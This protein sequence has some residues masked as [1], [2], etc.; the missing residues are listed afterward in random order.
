MR[1]VLQARLGCL[2]LGNLIASREAFHLEIEADHEPRFTS[3]TDGT[4]KRVPES[5]RA[6]VP[7][8]TRSLTST[9]CS[10]D[11]LR[12]TVEHTAKGGMG[13]TKRTTGSCA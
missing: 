11:N 5:Y 12:S 1:R 13:W 10:A 4:E 6:S 3:L 8:F 7:R 9:S 2:A